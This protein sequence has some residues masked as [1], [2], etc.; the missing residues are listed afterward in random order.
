[1][2]GAGAVAVRAGVGSDALLA[3]LIAAAIVALVVVTTARSGQ[4]GRN[5]PEEQQ[6]GFFKVVLAP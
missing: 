1:V 4:A 6:D 2:L 5:R 3:V